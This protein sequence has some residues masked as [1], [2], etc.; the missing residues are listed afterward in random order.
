MSITHRLGA[1]QSVLPVVRSD[2]PAGVP[3][4]KPPVPVAKSLRAMPLTRRY[5]AC[6]LT[7]DGTIMDSTRLAP[8]TPLFEEAFSAL[9]RGSVI[10]T[11]DGPVAVEDL[12]PGQRVLTAEGRSERVTWIGSMVIYPGAENGRDLEEQVSLT[13]ITAEAFGA[14]RPLLDVVLGPRARL[15]LRDPRLRRVSGLEAAYVPARA[16]I[17]GISVIEVTP[18]TPVTVYHAVLEH[19]GSIRVAGLE[20][21]AFHPGEGV[22]RMIDPRMLSL[23]E[24]QFP[25]IASLAELGPPAHPRLTRFEVESLWD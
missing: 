3:A 17:D 14:G 5:E 18:S 11:E 24:A 1:G 22:E 8:A 4:R 9:A 12:L 6:W 16:F 23:F 2:H 10:L 7:P 25:Q 19:H 20:V 21:E 15:C 13:R